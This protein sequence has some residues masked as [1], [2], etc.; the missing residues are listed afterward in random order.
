[1]NRASATKTISAAVAAFFAVGFSLI[2]RSQDV[3]V[4]PTDRSITV[5]GY[6]ARGLPSLDKEWSATDS[7]Q[8]WEVLQALYAEDPALLPRYGSMR[9]G[10]VFDKLLAQAFTM[11]AVFAAVGDVPVGKLETILEQE[12]EALTDLTLLSVYKLRPETGVFFDREL[13]EI[14]ARAADHF[15]DMWQEMESDVGK[16]DEVIA[17]ADTSGREEIVARI[18]KLQQRSE[19]TLASMEGF[20]LAKLVALVSLVDV[21]GLSPTAGDAVV[22]HGDRLVA[23]SWNLLSSDGRS[24]TEEL[25]AAARRGSPG[26]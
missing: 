26:D 23:K 12:P 7:K 21:P 16:T 9:S 5:A 15:V 19:E 4:V 13:V 18:R 11:E 14:L 2:A 1:V 3:L 22:A 6:A 17:N 20:F 8:A 10:S 25:L 24:A